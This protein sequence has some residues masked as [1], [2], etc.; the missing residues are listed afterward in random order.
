MQ[1]SPTE[2]K[3]L[4]ILG[5]VS[6]ECEERGSDILCWYPPAGGWM[7]I[8][9]KEMQDLVASMGDG[10]LAE[11]IVKMKANVNQGV[12]LVEGRGQWDSQGHWAGHGQRVA[13]SGLQGLLMTIRSTGVWVVETDRMTGQNSTYAWLEMLTKWVVKDGHTSLDNTRAPVD[14]TWGKATSVDYQRHLL[15]GLPGMGPKLAKLIVSAVGMPLTWRTGVLDELSALPGIGPKKIAAWTD[16]VQPVC[17]E[18]E[19]Q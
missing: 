15:L 4:K 7:G 6:S 2:P 16:A 12:L 8:Q 5:T 17:A 1:F 19:G 11:Q 14:K 3:E 13:W 10:R 18:A 9:R